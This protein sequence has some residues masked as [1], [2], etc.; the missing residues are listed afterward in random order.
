MASIPS[1]A[2]KEKLSITDFR[3][4]NHEIEI[5]KMTDKILP[6]VAAKRRVIAVLTENEIEGLYDD[7]PSELL[8][9]PQVHLLNYDE[10]INEPSHH[11]R[12]QSLEQRGLLEPGN[13]LIQ[14]PYSPD[15]YCLHSDALNQFSLKKHFHMSGLCRLLGATSVAVTQVEVESEKSTVTANVESGGVSASGEVSLER[16]LAEKL[17]KEMQLTDKFSGGPPDVGAARE[18]LERHRLLSDPTM[19]S[20]VEIME[21]GGNKIY[22][23][24]LTFNASSEANK[25]L[26]ICGKLELSKVGSLNVAFGSESTKTMDIKLTM[27]VTFPK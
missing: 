11:P 21:G 19:Q 1:A 3:A 6:D 5:E 13:V 27:K 14:N 17:S 16:R 22:E 7:D 15:E 26:A 24:Q 25:N 8:H 2:D 9:A 18:Y 10:A 4:G 12:L 23:R 20:L